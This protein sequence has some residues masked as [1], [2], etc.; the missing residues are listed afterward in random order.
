MEFESLVVVCH[1]AL[2]L[3]ILLIQAVPADYAGIIHNIICKEI[4]RH[5][6]SR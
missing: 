3:D 5:L 6:P 1:M 2:G 4:Q